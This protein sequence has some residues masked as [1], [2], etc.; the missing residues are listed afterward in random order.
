MTHRTRL[1]AAAVPAVAL[2]A[3]LLGTASARPGPQPR[4]DRYGDPLPP[5][6]V[7]RLGT[8]RLRHGGWP[9]ALTFSRDSKTLLS[10]SG[11]HTVRLW[12]VATGK[13]MDT[14]RS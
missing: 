8:E 11:G 4:L 1:L 13:L 3:L 9:L 12:D 14:L 6:A 2:A 5:G 7:A 10:G